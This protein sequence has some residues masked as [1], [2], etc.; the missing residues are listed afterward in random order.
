MD[1]TIVKHIVSLQH[2]LV[3]YLVELKKSRSF[4]LEQGSVL[5]EGKNCIIDLCKKRPAKRL[6]IQEDKILPQELL[7]A[8]YI[9]CTKEIIDKISSVVNSEGIIA[10]MALPSMAPLTQEKYIIA[11]DGLQDPGN[12]GTII[13]TALALGWQAIFLIEPCC[14]PFNDKALRAAKGAT[15]ELPIQRGTWDDLAEIIKKNNL[16]ALVADLDG[17]LPE[18][19]QEKSQAG[20]V[21]ILGN[22]AQG[23]HVPSTFCHK[24]IVIPMKGPMESLNVAIAA[25]ILMYTLRPL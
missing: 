6:L 22:E 25:G 18:A 17:M 14:D 9:T 24:K 4:R 21:L 11:C 13:R 20:F 12:L 15:F 10:E 3:K 8:E 7:S 2:P 16:T 19:I 5:L 1:K 23:A